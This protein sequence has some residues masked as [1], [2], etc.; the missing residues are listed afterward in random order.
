MIPWVI[1]Y[2]SPT[3]T[4]VLHEAF[5]NA[6]WMSLVK[7]VIRGY[8][9]KGTL[10]KVGGQPSPSVH[11][12][13]CNV[14]RHWSHHMCN[15]FLIRR[16]AITSGSTGVKFRKLTVQDVDRECQSLNNG[17]TCFTPYLYSKSISGLLMPVNCMKLNTY[18]YILRNC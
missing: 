1:L 6:W 16:T 9:M 2:Y 8:E 4:S 10:N 18:K 5:L 14:I 17:H 11:G 15:H 13:A 7:F 3:P 12:L